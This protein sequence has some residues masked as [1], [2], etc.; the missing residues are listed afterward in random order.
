MA[1]AIVPESGDGELVCCVIPKAKWMKV[2]RRTYGFWDQKMKV[3]PPIEDV[4]L[5]SPVDVTLSAGAQC[6]LGQRTLGP[7]TRTR[8][9]YPV[10]RSVAA[11]AVAVALVLAGRGEAANVRRVLRTAPTLVGLPGLASERYQNAVD[12]ILEQSIRNLP[13]YPAAS[14]A[15]TW[16]RNPDTGT[17]ERVS[18][19]VSPWFTERGETLGEGLVN[20][21]VTFGYFFVNCSSGC[22]IGD[23]PDPVSVSVAAVRYRALSELRYSVATFNVTYGLTDDLDLNVALPIATLDTDLQVTRQDNPGAPVRSASRTV[24][25]GNIADMLVRAKY[26]LFT[27]SNDFGGA[28]GAAGLRVRIP[29]GNPTRG[30]GTGYGEIGPYAA[31]STGAFDGWL[32]SYWDLGVDIGIGDLR[33][34]SAHYSWAID[35]HAPRG[36]DWWTRFALA[37]SVL[38]RSEFTDLRAPTSISGAHVTPSGI[39]DRPYLC[40]DADRHDYLD[41]VLGVRVLLVETIVLSLGVFKGFTEQGVRADW[42]PLASIEG[43]F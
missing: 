20:A 6:A 43:T 24:G 4:G 12:V 29:T 11:V 17:Y 22:E 30:L 41:T 21:G 26:R 7:K 16:R 36:D 31:L 27:T 42:S 19:E 14:S 8:A 39:V 13:L 9:V 40:A 32:D 33:R 18:D 37:L 23:D 35:L 10:R 2:Y 5:G 3:C 34:S 25:S 1:G 15:Y 28:A 38:G